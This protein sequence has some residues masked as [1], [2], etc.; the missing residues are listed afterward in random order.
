MPSES[1]LI[2]RIGTR[3]PSRRAG[4]RFGIGEDAA[5]VDLGTGI[6]LA[7]SCDWFLENTHFLAA[8]HPPDAIGFKALARATSDLAAMGASPQLFLTSLALPSR[9][10]GVWLDRLLSGMARAAREFGM[11]A[12]GGDT[13]SSPSLVL[14]ITVL[15]R[16]E[17]GRAVTRRGAR[18]GDLVCI[19]GHL[20]A[21][22][23]GLE[24]IL[25]GK[26]RDRRFDRLLGRHL[27]PRPRIALGRWISK[28]R[29]A[30][31]M[32][33]TSDGL[34]SDLERLCEAS[35]VG[36]RVWVDR[37]PL[38]PVPA[39]LQRQGVE[40]VELALH[41]GEDYE[42]LFTMAP[43]FEGLLR[44]GYQGLPLTVIGKITRQKQLV[45]VDHRG[46][47]K[48]LRPRGWDSF[49]SARDTAQRPEAG[50]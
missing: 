6:E 3:L 13:S 8:V 2:E 30:S 50:T 34:S 16:I 22:Q 10:T 38:T 45:L 35:G 43:R 29:L 18:A 40:P 41:G 5:I 7:V 48:A 44:G 23:L 47:A 36:A 11:V 4:L 19:S 24:L 26:H 32:I 28:R 31:A 15:G 1:R 21:A 25:R 9:R 27:Y 14:N 17:P 33:D 20:G 49:R 37:L 39:V 42:L 46:R 12:A